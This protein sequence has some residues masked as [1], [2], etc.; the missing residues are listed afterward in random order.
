[1]LCE[2]PYEICCVGSTVAPTISDLPIFITMHAR[3]AS[4]KS[5]EKVD[6]LSVLVNLSL[7][8][9]SY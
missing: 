8:W 2:V 1:M 9:L 5:P 6:Y 3:A 4:P 7:L